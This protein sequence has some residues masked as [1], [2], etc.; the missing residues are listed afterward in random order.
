MAK[1]TTKQAFLLFMLAGFSPLIKLSSAAAATYG[2]G[3]GWV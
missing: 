2:G 3:A 1:I